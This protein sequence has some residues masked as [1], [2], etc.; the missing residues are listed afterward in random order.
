M[1]TG[2]FHPGRSVSDLQRSL[3]FYTGALGIEHSR[4]QVSDQQYLAQV[5][6]YAGCSLKIGFVQIEG[7]EPLL[8]L[9]EHVNPRG[10]PLQPGSGRP[11][12]LHIAWSVDHLPVLLERLERQG[13]KPLGE[14]ALLTAG[15]WKGARGIFVQDPDGAL[16]ELVQLEDAPGGSGRLVHYH[17]AGLTVADLSTS[18]DLFC[19]KLGL[20]PAGEGSESL[21]YLASAGG[22]AD[23][24]GKWATLHIPGTR[25]F[26]ELVQWQSPTLPPLDMATCNPGSGHL[27]FRVRDIHEAYAE[28]SRRGIRFVGPPAAVTAGVNRGAYAIYFFTTDGFRCEIFQPPPAS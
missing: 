13:I 3:R 1:I 8:E 18:L 28:F 16:V 14:P 19:G 9:V 11:G 10:I 25:T 15:L 26:L 5:T 4:W 21:P 24:E 27:C 17:H 22:P 20:E 7:D 23:R 6:G 12:S 2:L